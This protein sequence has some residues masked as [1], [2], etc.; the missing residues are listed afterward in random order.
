MQTNLRSARKM[1]LRLESQ[2]KRLS[3]A[4]QAHWQS[5]FPSGF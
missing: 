3:Q 2:A 1:L 5:I 4:G